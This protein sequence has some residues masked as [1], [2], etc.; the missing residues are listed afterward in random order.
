MTKTRPRY[1]CIDDNL[2]NNRAYCGNQDVLVI[3]AAYFDAITLVIAVK[4]VGFF[5]I[6]Y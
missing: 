1:V 6:Y 5:G 3:T 2:Q 4:T